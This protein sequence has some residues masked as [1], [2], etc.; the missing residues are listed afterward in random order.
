MFNIA[1]AKDALK[2]AHYEVGKCKI[3]HTF[4]IETN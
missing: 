3:S 1:L 4:K 2:Y